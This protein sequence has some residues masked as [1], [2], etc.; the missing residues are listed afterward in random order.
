MRLSEVQTKAFNHKYPVYVQIVRNRKRSEKKY[1]IFYILR[2]VYVNGESLENVLNRT[3]V[4]HSL[5]YIWL[6]DIK[7]PYVMG[8]Y[9]FYLVRKQG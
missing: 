9:V 7:R 5:L 3:L 4:G 1:L 2:L 8:I 6:E